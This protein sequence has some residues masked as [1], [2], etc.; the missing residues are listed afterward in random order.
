MYCARLTGKVLFPG[1]TQPKRI[2]STARRQPTA[3]IL[4]N[5]ATTTDDVA[6]EAESLGVTFAPLHEDFGADIQGVDLKGGIS[7][8]HGALV[9]KAL[10]R[11]LLLRFR[12]QD[13]SP[14]EETQLLCCLPHDEEAMKN[15]E[16]ESGFKPTIPGYPHIFL[17]YANIVDDD[18]YGL[19]LRPKAQ[20][21][22]MKTRYRW[23]CDLPHQ[24]ACPRYSC[25]NMRV[26]PEH[27]GNT[28][29]ASG[30]KAY[31]LLSDDQK[32]IADKLRARYYNGKLMFKLLNTPNAEDFPSENG[33][34]YRNAALVEEMLAASLEEGD[35]I[36]GEGRPFVVEEEG[37]GVRSIFVN[38]AFLHC[39]DGMSPEASQKLLDEFLGPVASPERVWSADWEAGDVIVWKNWQ[40]THA[41][42]PWDAYGNQPRLFHTTFWGDVPTKFVE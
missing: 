39:F 15:G 30:V 14:A 9:K 16:L 13:I 35:S 18:Y 41:A 37:S 22:L 1:Q 6:V 31:E 12:G 23:H 3:R 5:G 20:S 11:F 28:L 42:P 33:Y 27:G 19:T 17:Q 34:G 2:A 8:T 40:M 7:K 4:R 26:A 10:D 36:D 24:E 38:T 32:S 21:S 25:M 29:F